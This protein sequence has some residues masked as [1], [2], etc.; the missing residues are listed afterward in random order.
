MAISMM[1]FYVKN[2][3]WIRQNPEV[4][5]SYNV[6]DFSSKIANL[7]SKLKLWN[8]SPNFGRIDGHPNYKLKSV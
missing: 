7:G 5:P 4:H 3:G 1:A 2:V 8:F 6:C